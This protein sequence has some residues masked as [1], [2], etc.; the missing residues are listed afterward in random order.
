MNSAPLAFPTLME[1]ASIL[2]WGSLLHGVAQQEQLPLPSP[3]FSQARSPKHCRVSPEVQGGRKRPKH[4]HSRKRVIFSPHVR[5]REIPV[6]APSRDTSD[7]DGDSVDIDR[8]EFAQHFWYSGRSIRKSLRADIISIKRDLRANPSARK[9]TSYLKAM[10]LG[11]QPGS[12]GLPTMAS[13][14]A[15]V[16]DE[17]QHQLL[18]CETSLDS[19]ARGLEAYFV[20][21]IKEWR[22]HVTAT[23]LRAQSKLPNHLSEEEKGILLRR[24]SL[25]LTHS[26]RHMAR[27]LGAGDAKVVMN[28]ILESR[29]HC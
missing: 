16:A 28:M 7:D 23:I 25:R 18:L 9:D 24:L 29:Y 22:Q 10:E 8:D 11:L 20:P 1:S 6:L 15:T 19:P 2:P 21:S 13:S 5:V 27:C 26:N 12:S 4:S 3:V 14:S 17:P